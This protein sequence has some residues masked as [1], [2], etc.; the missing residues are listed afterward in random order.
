MASRIIA[1]VVDCR[2]AESLAAFWCAALDYQVVRRWQDARGKE[3]VE[4]ATDGRPTLLFH[5]VPE[6]KTP[7]KNRLHLDLRPTDGNQDA[8]VRRLVG[9]GARVVSSEQDLP[10]VVLTDPEDNEFCVLPP[11]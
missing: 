2:D 10:W 9:L 11:G 4:A 7:G 1:V 6:G 8:E 5:P 3:Y